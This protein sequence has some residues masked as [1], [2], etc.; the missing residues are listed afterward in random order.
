MTRTKLHQSIL[1]VDRAHTRIEGKV[2]LSIGDAWNA[3]HRRGHRISTARPRTPTPPL[4]F[5]NR[6]RP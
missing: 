5:A 6:T 4:L 1:D 3:V 2:A